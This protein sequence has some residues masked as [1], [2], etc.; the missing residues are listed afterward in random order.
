MDATEQTASTGKRLQDEWRFL[1]LLFALAL[2]VRLIFLWQASHTPLFYAPNVD[3]GWHDRW[4]N[5]LLDHGWHYDG[6]YFRAPLYPYFLA[7][8]YAVSDRSILFARS[9]QMV[10]SALSVLLFYLL[11]RRLLPR[12]IARV[13][14]LFLCVY[15]TLIWYEQALLIPVLIIFLDLLLLYLLY[16]FKQSAR[17]KVLT[18]AGLVA[19]L[20]LIARPNIAIFILTAAI[21][22]FLHRRSAAPRTRRLAR[23][24]LFV[25]VAIL[26]LIPVTI[27]NYRATGDIIPI[28]SQGG[29]NFYLGNN[30]L[31][32]GLT[33]RM[34]EVVLDETIPWD[35]FV[36]TTDSIADALA[37]KQLSPGAVSGFWT[38]RML[39]YAV[40][41]PLDFL[42]GLARKA[43]FLFAGE[44]NSDNFDL[45][46]Y[47]KL[48]PIYAV[49]VWSY[50][51]HFPF[52]LV[53]PLALIGM[54]WLWR[55]RRDLDLLYIFIFTYAPTVIGVLVTARHRL[56]VVVLVIPFA[57]AAAFEFVRRIRTGPVR[58][59]IPWAVLLA[60]LLVFLNTEL[61]GLGFH[62]DAQSHLNLGQAYTKLGQTEAATQEFEAALALDSTSSVA[63]NNLSVLALRRG[64]LYYA[65][66]Y[67]QRSLALRPHDRDVQNNLATLMLRQGLF[68]EAAEMLH[69]LAQENPTF[70]E[71]YFNLAEIA[72]NRQQYDSALMYY[73][74][75]LARDPQ[76]AEAIHNKGSVYY[77]LGNDSLALSMWQEAYRL[78]PDYAAA[79]LNLIR[80]WRARGVPDSLRAILSRAQGAWRRSADWYAL[81]AE[82]A[83]DSGDRRKARSLL[84]DALKADSTNPRAIR[85]SQRLGE[86]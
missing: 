11:F 52:G 22:I 44:E 79:A 61:W 23:A 80:T 59:W 85:L 75:A 57:V 3:E 7:A 40:T 10:L 65:R 82:L 33:M 48:V 37:G 53:S 84:R 81:S 51:L 83:L 41:Q 30:P 56:P 72:T 45:Y 69:R 21:W 26:P 16:V 71:P 73:D 76:F 32:N 58:R 24:G 74:S 5:E 8:L 4:A 50:G 64:D 47:R 36:P 1:L 38:G 27:H 19:G 28:A 68:D 70:A 49:L 14:A 35:R 15:G 55:R 17:L 43:Y 29:I 13:S 66:T 39:Q 86:N 2:A 6:V 18:L 67:L 20:S 25:G 54:V 63:L 77:R 78:R 60:A 42:G 12:N 62:N 46:Y 34:P 9:A 31:A